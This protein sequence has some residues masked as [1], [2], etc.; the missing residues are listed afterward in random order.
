MAEVKNRYLI[1]RVFTSTISSELK[2]I[3]QGYRSKEQRDNPSR[4]TV[5]CLML[6]FSCFS[7][8]LK[9]RKVTIEKDVDTR[10][11][12]VF[13]PLRVKKKNRNLWTLEA[14]RWQSRVLEMKKKRNSAIQ[15]C[16]RYLSIMIFM[17][18][19]DLFMSWKLRLSCFCLFSFCFACCYDE[20][21]YVL[22][23]ASLRIFNFVTWKMRVSQ[24]IHSYW[25]FFVYDCYFRIAVFE[26]DF[27]YIVQFWTISRKWWD[28]V[29]LTNNVL[30]LILT[31]L[32]NDV[33]A[34]RCVS[35]CYYSSVV[36]LL[37]GNA[38]LTR[39]LTLYINIFAVALS[40][41]GL[42]RTKHKKKTK[43]V[44]AWQGLFWEWDK[45]NTISQ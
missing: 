19:K 16:S 10:T 17:L 42:R 37:P 27:V 1:Y 18:T 13:V 4:I 30:R 26:F 9:A 45:E 33:F 31:S 32:L 38:A 24:H 34:R 28:N 21:R 7:L 35:C 6:Y 2:M 14:N 23:T 43:N 15:W 39:I 11:K 44:I 22:R 5:H 36:V 41:G 29:P 25:S 8:S 20:T 3:P 12:A 40:T